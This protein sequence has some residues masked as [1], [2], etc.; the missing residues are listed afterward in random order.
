MVRLLALLDQLELQIY[1]VVYLM[2]YTSATLIDNLYISAIFYKDCSSGILISDI[3]DH[4]PIFVCVGVNPDTEIK[5]E[6]LSFTYRNLDDT[7]FI[8]LRELLNNEDWDFFQELNINDAFIQ[9]HNILRNNIETLAPEKNVIPFHKQIREPWFTI[10]L[11]KSSKTLD[12][13]YKKKLR[14]PLKHPSYKQYKEYRNLLNAL[15]RTAK[16]D[17]YSNLLNN[18]KQDIKQTWKVLRPLIGK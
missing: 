8:M 3:S 13:L 12:K 9:L 17:Y 1:G 6:A 11:L 5:K 15:K 16:E 14:Q 4:F 7:V 10:G 18:Y 2:P